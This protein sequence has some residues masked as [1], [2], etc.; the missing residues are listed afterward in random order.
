[1]G[2]AQAGIQLPADRR[3]GSRNDVEQFAAL[4]LLPVENLR[5]PTL[6]IHG[7]AEKLVPYTHA[8]FIAEKVPGAELYAIKDGTHAIFATHY[9]QVL[10]RLFAFLDAHGKDITIH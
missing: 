4:P 10:A 5:V 3:A 6:V 2:L 7:T 1:M 9:T 8:P